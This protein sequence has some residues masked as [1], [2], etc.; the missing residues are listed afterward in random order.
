MGLGLGWVGLALPFLTLA[1]VESPPAL[2]LPPPCTS[3]TSEDAVAAVVWV[4]G[5]GARVGT[6]TASRPRLIPRPD[7]FFREGDFQ[8]KACC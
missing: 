4:V 2:P 1:C 5:A 3:P 6:G 7:I 8:R